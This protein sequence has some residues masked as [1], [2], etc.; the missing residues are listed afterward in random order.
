MKD[1]LCVI[2]T[3]NPTNVLLQTI[4]NYKPIWNRN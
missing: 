3:K 4:Q 2:S 1:R